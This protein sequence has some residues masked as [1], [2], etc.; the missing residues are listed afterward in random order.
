MTCGYRN[1]ILE[2]ISSN[3]EFIEHNQITAKGLWKDGAHLTVSGE[4][5]L[6]RNLLDKINVFFATVGLK[7]QSLLV[8]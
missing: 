3:V 5:F 2:N 7:T 6:A 8:K 1:V 4:V